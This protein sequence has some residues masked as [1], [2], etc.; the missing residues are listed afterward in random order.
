MNNIKIL[1][2]FR[3]AL[4]LVCV[5]SIYKVIIH[6][7]KAQVVNTITQNEQTQAPDAFNLLLIG[8]DNDVSKTTGMR[9]A[10]KTGMRNDTNIVLSFTPK[11]ERGDMS[12]K[13]ISIPRDVYVYVP[14]NADVDGLGMIETMNAAMSQGFQYGYEAEEP[15]VQAGINCTVDTAET[16]LDT[17]IDYYMSV[18]FSIFMKIVDVIDGVELTWNEEDYCEQ[19]SQGK[20]QA[21]CFKK[22]VKQKMNGEMALAFAR[23]RHHDAQG[24]FSTSDRDLR[25]QQ[26][27]GAVISK[28]IKNPDKY[29][30]AVGTVVLKEGKTN[31]NDLNFIL[32]MARYGAN[33]Y[34]Q[35]IKALSYGQKIRLDVIENAYQAKTSGISPFNI[36]GV[37]E[38]N[39]KKQDPQDVY[40]VFQPWEQTDNYVYQFLI[41]NEM[42]NVPSSVPPQ[43]ETTPVKAINM[44][45]MLMSPEFQSIDKKTCLAAETLS[46]VRNN[47]RNGK[48]YNGKYNPHINDDNCTNILYKY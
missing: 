42:L 24:E 5:F 33:F 15:G 17:Q 47:L 30:V 29:A 9:A 11:N 2:I 26:V 48:P 23:S 38:Q 13:M 10:D 31:I 18:D 3:V 7:V 27:I 14:C 1:R 34:Q 37:S 20:Q 45:L 22:G 46:S 43:K 8:T 44:E 21:F 25:Q 16:Y 40:K 19:D 39:V 12:L 32:S 35:Q 36:L 41:T 4:I 6:F 28:I